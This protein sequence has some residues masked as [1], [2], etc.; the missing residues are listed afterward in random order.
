MIRKKH[1][2]YLFIGILIAAAVVWFQL[3]QFRA[4]YK[5]ECLARLHLTD[6]FD[7]WPDGENVILLIGDSRIFQWQPLFQIDGF[8]VANLGHPG[9]TS[10][11]CV[12]NLRRLDI[13]EQAKLAVVQVGIND[14]KVIG[15]AP[16]KREQIIE[17]LKENLQ[18]LTDYLNSEKIQTVLMPVLPAAEPSLARR[19]VWSEGI[20]EAVVEINQWI[21]EMR[22]D[23][24]HVPDCQ[25]LYDGDFRLNE[26]YATDTLHL[27]REGYAVLNKIVAETIRESIL[28]EGIRK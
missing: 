27:N 11:E 16:E 5:K 2:L 8:E 10:Y 12:A 19:V 17:S 14:V 6:P 20:D 9:M 13:P 26:Q 21:N 24:I 28:R 22:S 15:V 4:S 1:S 18:L 7:A 23:T 25:L 3:V